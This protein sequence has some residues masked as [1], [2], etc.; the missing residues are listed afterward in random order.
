MSII[1][2]SE[3]IRAGL[4]KDQMEPGGSQQAAVQRK[5]RGSKSRFFPGSALVFYFAVL[6]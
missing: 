6:S 4:R 2:K 5:K 3:S 1:E